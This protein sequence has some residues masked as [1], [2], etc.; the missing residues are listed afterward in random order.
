MTTI[1]I[2]SQVENKLLGRKE[3]TAKIGFSGPTP[4]RKDIRSTIGGKIGANPELMVL[5]EVRNEF[6]T[7]NLTVT[8]HIYDNVELM[9]KNELYHLMVR[10]GLA[11][12]KEKKKKVKKVAAPKKQ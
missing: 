4:N 2:V 3:L 10:D 12:K 8:A 1:E 9:K 7:T 11:P 5:G 6:G